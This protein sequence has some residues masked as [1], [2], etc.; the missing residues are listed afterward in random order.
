MSEKNSWNCGLIFLFVLML[1]G[2]VSVAESPNPRFYMPGPMSQGEAGQKIEIASGVIVAIGPIKI[3]EYQD[4]PQI[5][6]KNKN[7]TFNFAQFDRWAEPLDSAL[8]RL[9]NDNLVSL[10][11]QAS[12]QLFP[13]SFAIPLDYQVIV[14]VIQIDSQ[15]DKELAL[16]AQ[17]SIIDAKNRKLLLTKRSQFTQ[18]INPHD[19]FGLTRALSLACSALS[20]DIAEN[21]ANI[22]KNPK[23]IKP[24]TAQ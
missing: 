17:W 2:C 21:L 12:F 7:G 13:C 6:T 3:P 19:Y 11:P 5:V 4:R 16:T 8:A 15:L 23:P 14:D 18:A 24:N 20:R 10:L 9:I 22:S 1:G